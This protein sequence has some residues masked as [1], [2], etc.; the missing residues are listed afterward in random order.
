MRVVAGLERGA[1]YDRRRYV[2]HEVRLGSGLSA[3][4]RP[5]LQ[6]LVVDLS[7]G[8]CG[9]ELS[10]HLEEGARVW[11]KLPGMESLPARVAWTEDGRAGLAFDHPLH[12][13]VVAHVAAKGGGAP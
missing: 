8:G 2:R 12:P 7:A 3:N 5:S 11:L 10:I 13:A 9:I 4:I 1:A 6:V